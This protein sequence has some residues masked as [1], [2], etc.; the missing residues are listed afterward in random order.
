MANDGS[1]QQ[2]TEWPQVK[3]SFQVKWDNTEMVFQEVT[4][5]SSETQVIEYR[6]DNNK[7]FSTIKMPG[8][9][10]SGNVTLKKGIFKGDKALWDKFNAIKMNTVKRSN[11][12]VSLLD[13]NNAVAMTWT[14][15]NAFPSKITAT[16]LKADGNEVA[17]ET[18][19]L[20]HEGLTLSS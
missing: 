2:Q 12:T 17:V 5:L 10:K 6:G 8:I 11:I 19:E 16:D 1:R 18:I 13:E 4:G 3:F 7:K 14:L 9:Q 20:A 15:T